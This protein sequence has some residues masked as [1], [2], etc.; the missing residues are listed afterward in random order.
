[1]HTY[2][3]LKPHSTGHPVGGGYKCGACGLE[4]LAY[5]EPHYRS[6]DGSS[7]QICEPPVP[8]VLATNHPQR[9]FAGQKVLARPSIGP[10]NGHLLERRGDDGAWSL[11]D[12]GPPMEDFTVPTTEP[13][14]EGV[15]TREEYEAAGYD[16]AGYDERFPIDQPAVPGAPT[17]DIP[18]EAVPPQPVPNAQNTQGG[19]ALETK[20]VADEELV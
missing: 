14:R 12:L 15:P 20:S 13:R 9:S 11:A 16:P 1:M 19:G 18:P 7:S 4:G 17:N 8:A 2:I 3:P 10:G 6:G 5:G